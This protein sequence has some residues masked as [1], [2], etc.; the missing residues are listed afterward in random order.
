MVSINYGC[1]NQWPKLWEQVLE[2]M[3]LE[4]QVSI[5][6]VVTVWTTYWVMF[7]KYFISSSTLKKPTY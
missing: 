3:F 5:N 2:S 1:K 4:L 7:D 6:R